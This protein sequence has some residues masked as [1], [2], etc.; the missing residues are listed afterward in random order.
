MLSSITTSHLVH[1]RG[2][3]IN[4]ENWPMF[5]VRVYYQSDLTVVV[6]FENQG[7]HISTG[8]R[9]TIWKWRWVWGGG[10]GQREGGVWH[11][12]RI[13]FSEGRKGFVHDAW[14]SLK[15][16]HEAWI[17]QKGKG[18][19]HEIW[20]V[21]FWICNTWNTVWCTN[22]IWIFLKFE[23]ET[24]SGHSLPPPPLL[25]SFQAS[26]TQTG[27]TFSIFPILTRRSFTTGSLQ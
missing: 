1:E 20:S 9:G 18:G 4:V 23:C 25:P 14:L 12:N 15:I 13:W 27:N 7:F 10:G 19:W 6:S 26:E 17:L 2:G 8:F 24:E 11:Q 3:N 5:Q 22:D 21:H 16:M